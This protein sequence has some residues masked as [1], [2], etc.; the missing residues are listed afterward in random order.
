MLLVRA[1]DCLTALLR[2]PTATAGLNES[3]YNVLDA[4]RRIPTG[5]SAQSELAVALLQSESNLSTLL[6]RMQHDGLISRVRSETDRRKSLIRLTA[7]GSEALLRADH[8]RSS[9]AA[10]ILRTL[11]EESTAALCQAL[12]RLLLRF[13][14]ELGVADRS[15]ALASV[16]AGSE[17]RTSNVIPPP[18]H[19][20]AK[21][22][23]PLEFSQTSHGHTP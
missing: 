17:A 18:H 10:R 8:E 3:R 9:A 15:P 6:D 4:L 16:K 11:D 13:E 5:T 23:L 14:R 2:A 12:E 20:P 19:R 22:S 7:A 1:A 21:S